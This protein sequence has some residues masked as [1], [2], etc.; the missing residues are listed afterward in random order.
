MFL[1]QQKFFLHGGSIKKNLPGC[2]E[3]SAANFFLF[4]F[5]FLLTRDLK[6]FIFDFRARVAFP[7]KD[8]NSFPQSITARALPKDMKHPFLLGLIIGLIVGGIAGQIAML[9]RLYIE[10]MKGYNRGKNKQP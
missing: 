3:K 1:G 10:A 5:T 9:V 6:G 7:K 8:I 2:Q 4:L